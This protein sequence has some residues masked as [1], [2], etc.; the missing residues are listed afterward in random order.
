MT[1]VVFTKSDWD[2]Y[3]K[4]YDDLNMLRPYARMLADVTKHLRT[5]PLPIMDAGCGTGN[6]IRA[7]PQRNRRDVV[8]VDG[9]KAMLARAKAKNT[10]TTFIHADL[11]AR[12]PFEDMS[13][14]TVVCVNALYAFLDPSKS[15][16][17][18]RRILRKK[19]RLIVVTPKLGYENGL[20]LKA[21][22][23]SQKPDSYWQDAHG[24]ET[25]E[26]RLLHE[27]VKDEALAKRF[28]W[29][30]SVNRVIACER[31]FRFFTAEELANLASDNGF[32]DARM[33]E[34]Y[35]HQNLLLVASR[36]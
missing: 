3:A 14:G 19:G 4:W 16:G 5:S 25:R 30:A 11:N 9:S 6:L 31:S 35:A 2:R 33:K 8:G 22:C 15:L 36:T 34:T 1:S 28:L 10:D 18:F 29:I 24:N 21:H 7:L 27:A 23:R 13:F 32:A 12:L 20:I 26:R 17:E